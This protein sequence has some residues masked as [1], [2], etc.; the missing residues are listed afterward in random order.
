MTLYDLTKEYQ[1]LLELL[2]D[3]EAPE[4]AVN[5]TLSMVLMDI[6]DKAEGYGQVLKQMQ[7]DAEALKAEKLRIASRQSS[8]EKNIERLRG[9]MLH[10]MLI[11]GQTKIK[12]PL[13]S[14]STRTT[15]RIQLDVPEDKIPTQFQKV[16]VKADTKAIEQFMK[17]NAILCT[18]FAHFEPTQSLM[19]R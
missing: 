10:A 14:F 1:D 2:E 7:A 16:T 15:Q 6:N 19:V 11:T 5:D 18:E 3:G 9:A 17:D 12:T 13:F 4:E 8:L